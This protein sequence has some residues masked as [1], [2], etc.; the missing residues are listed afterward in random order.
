M[1]T[2]PPLRSY[3]PSIPIPQTCMQNSE[4]RNLELDSFLIIP[5]QRICKYPLLL[6]ELLKSTPPGHTDFASLSDAVEVISFVFSLL[7]NFFSFLLLFLSLPSN[8]FSK[9][10]FLSNFL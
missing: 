3:P 1:E 8:F 9:H 2:H 10:Y 6:K 5:L 7:S 4:T